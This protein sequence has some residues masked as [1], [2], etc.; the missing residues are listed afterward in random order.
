MSFSSDEEDG[1]EQLSSK[2]SINY[3]LSSETLSHLPLSEIYD[4][5]INFIDSKD[6]KLNSITDTQYIEWYK[7]S[8][9]NPSEFWSKVS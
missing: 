6:R 4:P 7:E 9:E 1:L 3:N 2:L 8:I 5:K